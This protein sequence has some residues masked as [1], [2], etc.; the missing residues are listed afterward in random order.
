ML[1]IYSLHRFRKAARNKDYSKLRG[2]ISGADPWISVPAVVNLISGVAVGGLW[3]HWWGYRLQPL[4]SATVEQAH[5]LPW[6]ER[7]LVA[8]G[9]LVW[10]LGVALIIKLFS[11][12]P[13]YPRLTLKH[14]DF[15]TWAA[16]RI[17]WGNKT[18]SCDLEENLKESPDGKFLKAWALE[19]GYAAFGWQI[20]SQPILNIMWIALTL[21]PSLI[22]HPEWL[23]ELVSNQQGY[24]F[25]LE[26]WYSL[27]IYLAL[28]GFLK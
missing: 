28:D 2:M 27:G 1:S 22:S 24:L 9:G 21:A 25:I 3:I 4:V 5:H 8:S 18:R 15:Q 7:K 13:D 20:L 23:S 10:M 6:H 17:V 14:P 11:N 26:A 12:T 16:N 19:V